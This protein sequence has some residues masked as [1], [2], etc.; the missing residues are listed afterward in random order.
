MPGRNGT[1][2]AGMGPMTGRGAGYCAG[3]TRPFSGWSA[4]MGFGRGRGFGGGGRFGRCRFFATEFP[5][6]PYFGRERFPAAMPDPESE[7]MFLEAEAKALQAD[8]NQVQ[9]RLNEIKGEES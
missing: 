2:P 8:L 7:R 4:G 9:K 5:E 1:G 3:Y 6:G